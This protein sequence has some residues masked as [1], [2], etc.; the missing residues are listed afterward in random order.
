MTLDGKY[1]ALWLLDEG[2][3][4]ILG[5]EKAESESRWVVSGIVEDSED[6]LG[7][8][9]TVDKFEERRPPP[10]KRVIYKVTP[11]L[12]LIRREFIITAQVLGTMAPDSREIGFRLQ[13]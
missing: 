6:P 8:W 1:L 2:A 10:D 9:I 5:I 7:F 4:S 12:C 13:S 11:P 3:R